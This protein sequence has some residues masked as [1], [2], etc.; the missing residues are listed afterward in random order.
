[1]KRQN[2][3]ELIITFY[4]LKA[5]KQLPVEDETKLPSA[6]TQNEILPADTQANQQ[7]AE[8][9]PEQVITH[10]QTSGK[11]NNVQIE[12]NNEIAPRPTETQLTLIESDSK[13]QSTEKET[14]GNISN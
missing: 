4:Q 11:E 8:I 9:P 14:A 3:L 10:E 12:P 13:P 6:E 1:M 2:Q 7:Q 5:M